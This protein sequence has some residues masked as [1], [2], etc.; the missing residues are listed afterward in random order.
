MSAPSLPLWDSSRRSGRFHFPLGDTHVLPEELSSME[1]VSEIALP[2]GEP[3]PQFA[4]EEVVFF[5]F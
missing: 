5:F 1:D 3:L 2:R 4:E